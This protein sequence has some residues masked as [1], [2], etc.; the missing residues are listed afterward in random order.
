MF[1]MAPRVAGALP[2][3]PSESGESGQTRRSVA[4]QVAST[5][6]VLPKVM[7]HSRGAPYC[8]F[9]GQAWKDPSLAKQGLE[10]RCFRKDARG[11]TADWGVR[12]EAQGGVNN[13]GSGFW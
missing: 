6:T 8:A 2:T 1:F 7:A 3:A 4:A 13:L 12:V 11:R 10:M 9:L 5:F